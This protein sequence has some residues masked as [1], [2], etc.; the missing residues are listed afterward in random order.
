MKVIVYSTKHFDPKLIQ[1]LRS[2]LY[3]NWTFEN[4]DLIIFFGN[5]SRLIA[6]SPQI[7]RVI[8]PA[9]DEGSTTVSHINVP[10]KSSHYDAFGMFQYL[11]NSIEQ[12]MIFIDKSMDELS[13]GTSILETISNNT[14]RIYTALSPFSNPLSAFSKDFHIFY[15]PY[16]K[17][18]SNTNFEKNVITKPSLHDFQTP[19]LGV[20]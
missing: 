1:K 18:Q 4:L 2:H 7:I 8:S 5:T 14:H 15:H 3:V 12:Q 9:N 13:V 10:E 11:Y 6:E 20:N 19:V 17:I 16:S